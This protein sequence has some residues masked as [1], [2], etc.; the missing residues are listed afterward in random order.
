[1]SEAGAREPGAGRIDVREGAGE[2]LEVRLSGPWR[3][4]RGLPRADEVLSRASTGTQRIALDGSQVS[5]WDTALLAFLVGLVRGGRERGVAVELAGLPAG[6]TRLVGLA[7]AVPPHEERAEDTE[8]GWLE[9]VGAYSLEGAHGVRAV[10]VF[11]GEATLAFGRLLAGRARFRAVDLWHEI[12]ECG[13]KAL[14]IVGL[15]SFLIGLILA[16][17]GAVQL[18]MFGAELYVANL[19]AIGMAREMSAMM[20]GVVLTGRTGAAYA[21]QLGTMT[22]NE[23][24]D[25]LRTLGISPME[26]LVLPRMLAL[27]LMTPLLAVYANVLGIL[28]GFV[29]GTGLLDITPGRYWHQTLDSVDASDFGVGLIKAA[30]VGALVAI[31]GCLRGLQSGRSAEAVGLATTS[32]VVTG[33][34]LIV[35]S[36]AVFAVL[37]QALGI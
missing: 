5:A 19:V 20:T 24:I 25:S 37:F 8:G 28:G 11:L 29:V 13:V 35:I 6:V 31:A 15:V 33:I 10:L 34:V 36:E 9:R 2:V 23:E 30:V 32:A 14:G 22:V 17:M 7:F 1:M 27:I 12:Q 18:E 26:F 3:M 16:Y 4:E 21:A